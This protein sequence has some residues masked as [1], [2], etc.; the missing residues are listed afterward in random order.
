MHELLSP[1]DGATGD[2]R[3]ANVSPESTHSRKKRQRQ[4]VGH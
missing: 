4:F 3:I 1:F 2:D